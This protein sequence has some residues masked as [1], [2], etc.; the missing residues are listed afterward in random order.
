MTGTARV[1]A[2]VRHLVSYDRDLF[3]NTVASAGLS[4]CI[5]P[6]RMTAEDFV[7]YRNIALCF[8]IVAVLQFLAVV[9]CR[10]WVKSDLRQRMCQP[11]RVW[12]RPFAWRTNWLACSFR[13]LYSDIH[14]Q[15][16]RSICWTYWHRPSV[17][18]D[19][20]EIVG[21]QP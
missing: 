20:D 4:F 8:C 9:L 14:G 21:L 5:G 13:V 1:S 19:R 18:W 12:W 16:H 3:S 10:E 2:S 7:A 6:L 15:I 11:I 17:T